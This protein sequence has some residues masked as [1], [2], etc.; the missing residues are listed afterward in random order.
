[1]NPYKNRKLPVGNLDFRVDGLPDNVPAQLEFGEQDLI[2]DIPKRLGKDYFPTFCNLG[3]CMG[4]SAILLAK[5]IMDNDLQ[6]HV[7]TIDNYADE[8]AEA[9]RQN[10]NKFGV[11]DLITQVRMTTDEAAEKWKSSTF[12]FIFIDADHAFKNVY[13]DIISY[14]D[15]VTEDGLLAF[16]D[17]NQDAVDQAIKDS[18]LEEDWL[19]IEWV[20]RIKVFKRK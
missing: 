3:D 10:Y 2:Y 19:L 20:N 6:G 17:T 12:H 14:K 8:Q 18:K 7:Y 16:H 5:G 4:G 15:K 9:A 13:N 1:M 11:Q